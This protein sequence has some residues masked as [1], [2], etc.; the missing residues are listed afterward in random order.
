MVDTSRRE[1]LADS[2][3]LFGFAR[4]NGGLWQLA[5]STNQKDPEFLALHQDMKNLEEK[6]Y[7]NL[8]A[9]PKTRERFSTLSGEKIPVLGQPPEGVD[10]IVEDT[11]R[12]RTAKLASRYGMRTSKQACIFTSGEYVMVQDGGMG[13]GVLIFGENYMIFQRNRFK[14]DEKRIGR[15][16]PSI[17][18]V[19]IPNTNGRYSIKKSPEVW[20]GLIPYFK[21][22]DFNEIKERV[23]EFET[24]YK[25]SLA[26]GYEVNHGIPGL[27]N[28]HLEDIGYMLI[29]AIQDSA[30]DLTLLSTFIEGDRIVI[31]GWSYHK[32][33]PERLDVRYLPKV[34]LSI[35]ADGEVKY[36][37]KD[38]D[39]YKSRPELVADRKEIHADLRMQ[40]PILPSRQ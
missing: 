38:F 36:S 29:E 26:M 11:F 13:K 2:L 15:R 33:S 4:G 6:L 18:M 30:D 1:F 22:G 35:G 7:A 24:R 21:S 12:N 3:L 32:I 19:S 40:F 17:K 16:W 5:D 28:R 8:P 20:N 25:R 10:E 14:S 37:S 27:M 34:K 39:T 9:V 31:E 23:K